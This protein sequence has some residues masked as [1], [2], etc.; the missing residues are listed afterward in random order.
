MARTSARLVS[1]DVP[2]SPPSKQESTIRRNTRSTRSQSVDL[3]A[4]RY[5]HESVESSQSE[6]RLR[7]RSVARKTAAARDLSIVAEGGELPSDKEDDVEGKEEDGEEGDEDPD[8]TKVAEQSDLG[9]QEINPPDLENN[10]APSPASTSMSVTTIHT[11]HI[12]RVLE[13]IDS[14]LAVENLPDLYDTARLIINKCLIINKS[15]NRKVRPKDMEH[16]SK[17]LN[18]LCKTFE[19]MKEPY[20]A[21]QFIEVEIVIKKLFASKSRGNREIPL[22]AILHSANL[23]TLGCLVNEQR[24]TD[25]HQDKSGH[26]KWKVFLQSLEKT[27]PGPFVSKFAAPLYSNDSANSENSKLIQESFNMLLDIRTQLFINVSRSLEVEEPS[28]DPDRALGTLLLH[29]FDEKGVFGSMGLEEW[30]ERVGERIDQIRETFKSAG[31]ATGPG[32][33][34]DFDELDILYPKS[35]FYNNLINYVGKRLDEVEKLIEARSGIGNVVESLQ[36]LLEDVDSEPEIEVDYNPPKSVMERED[37]PEMRKEVPKQPPYK[38][39]RAFKKFL[40]LKNKVGS[41][42][43]GD[44]ESP[45]R[46]NTSENARSSFAGPSRSQAEVQ[47]QNSEITEAVKAFSASQNKENQGPDQRQG[48]QGRPSIRNTATRGMYKH[49]PNSVKETWVEDSQGFPD[50]P[51]PRINKRKSPPQELQTDDDKPPQPTNNKRRRPPSP[52]VEV[53]NED[54]SSD[55]GFQEYQGKMPPRRTAT[56]ISSTRPSKRARTQRDENSRAQSS[57]GGH[58]SREVSS[59]LIG[60]NDDRDEL[61]GQVASERP[62]QQVR[63]RL[64]PSPSAQSVEISD[65]ES[66]DE[67]SRPVRFSQTQALARVNARREASRTAAMMSQTRAGWSDDDTERLVRYIE[68]HGAVWSSIEKVEGHKFDRENI[69]QVN[70]KDRARNIKVAMLLAGKMLPRNFDAIKLNASLLKRVRT[71]WPDYDPNTETGYGDF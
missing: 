62:S 19:T 47:Q 23:A 70:L 21:E 7:S 32:M 56:F 18:S 71:T 67:S 44:R 22:S 30:E 53:D 51:R 46:Y 60:P 12:E 11:V 34:V 1:R 3:D 6:N 2:S 59:P 9:L 25:Y 17:V 35:E 69:T 5:R 29:S 31:K 65:D 36:D 61:R 13:T 43:F 48:S 28:F 68:R 40:E 57:H 37:K 66:D 26:P 64:Q 45:P 54:S 33:Y 58:G 42:Q 24:Q 8:A 27:F 4:R 38:D 63:P 52:E 39:P 49:H 16:Q 15:A 50:P 41:R 14:S 20:G 10:E 55:Q